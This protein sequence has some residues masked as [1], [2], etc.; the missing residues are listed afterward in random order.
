[1]SDRGEATLLAAILGA[2][3]TTLPIAAGATLAVSE[4]TLR[5][6]QFVAVVLGICAT[7]AVPAGVLMRYLV[8]KA[9]DEIVDVVRA[10]IKPMRDEL[11]DVAS[12]ANKAIERLD[13]VHPLP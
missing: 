6:A 13:E 10:E 12:M 2:A 9:K 1:M 5:N 11:S 4:S 7:V 8:R 3:L